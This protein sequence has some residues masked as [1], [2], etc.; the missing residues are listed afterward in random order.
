MSKSSSIK[1]KS[2]LY[3]NQSCF[4]MKVVRHNPSMM[5]SVKV[6]EGNLR[7]TDGNENAFLSRMFSQMMKLRLK[8]GDGKS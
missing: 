6:E 3:S 2:D 4:S 8:L 7:Q 5:L 1:V